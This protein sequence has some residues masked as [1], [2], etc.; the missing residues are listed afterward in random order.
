MGANEAAVAS[1][2]EVHGARFSCRSSP[3]CRGREA[4][5]GKPGAATLA[6]ACDRRPD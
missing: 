2:Q 6:W 5:F 4:A 1:G 3:G